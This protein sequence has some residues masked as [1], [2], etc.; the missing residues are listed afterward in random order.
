MRGGLSYVRIRGNEGSGIER[1]DDEIGNVVVEVGCPETDLVM[2]Q[3][4]FKSNV[5]SGAG[6]RS[7]ISDWR[8]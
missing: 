1:P 6:F 8:Q 5:E 3:R 2:Q 4:L 7:K